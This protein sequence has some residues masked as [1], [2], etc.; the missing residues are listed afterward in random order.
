MDCLPRRRADKS[1][2]QV[3][4]TVEIATDQNIH[5]I[6]L[7]IQQRALKVFVTILYNAFYFVSLLC[8]EYVPT[9][10]DN[11]DSKEKSFGNQKLEEV[12]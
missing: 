8:L 4:L 9:L 5:K 3:E 2:C 10:L 12:D 1:V 11:G 7:K 6:H